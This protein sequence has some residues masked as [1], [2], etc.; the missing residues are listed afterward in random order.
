MSVRNNQYC[1]CK[2]NETN[3]G[4]EIVCCSLRVVISQVIEIR[5]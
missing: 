4:D 3:L 1:F 5:V 2:T